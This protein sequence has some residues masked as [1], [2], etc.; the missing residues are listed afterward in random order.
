MALQVPPT[1][2]LHAAQGEIVESAVVDDVGDSDGHEGVDL[3]LIGGCDDGDDA[4]HQSP[5]A[6]IVQYFVLVLTTNCEVGY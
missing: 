5:S 2:T 4:H 6:A 1:G 3:H